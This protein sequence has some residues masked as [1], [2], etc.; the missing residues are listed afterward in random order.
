MQ[1]VRRRLH[2]PTGT[3]HLSPARHHHPEPMPQAKMHT[4][5]IGRHMVTMSIRLNLKS[6]LRHSSNSIV[7]IM[8]PKVI[9]EERRQRLRVMPHHPLL[10]NLDYMIT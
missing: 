4:Q 1:A 8:L 9:Q 2:Q 7:S 10:E 5:L 6:G 3:I